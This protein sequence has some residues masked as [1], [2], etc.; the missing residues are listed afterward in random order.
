[1]FITQ[2]Q[3]VRFLLK[4]KYESLLWIQEVRPVRVIGNLQI[5]PNCAIPIFQALGLVL[6]S[7][8]L[9]GF[10]YQEEILKGR[11]NIYVCQVEL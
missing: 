7:M 4:T 2:W 1:M 3:T 10:P 11:S 5:L 6:T 9:G 8:P